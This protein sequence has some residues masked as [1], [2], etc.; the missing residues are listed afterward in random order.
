[1]KQY[2]ALLLCIFGIVNGM[3]SSQQNEKIL[4]EINTEISTLKRVHDVFKAIKQQRNDY[5]NTYFNLLPEDLLNSQI[6]TITEQL[7]QLENEK[8]IYVDKIYGIRNIYNPRVFSIAG[9]Y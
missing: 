3:Q 4:S 1:M 9:Y 5:R 6:E 7:K 8:K 2:L